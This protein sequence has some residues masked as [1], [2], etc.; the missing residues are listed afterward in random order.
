MNAIPRIFCV[1]LRE[2]PKRREEAIKYFQQ[3]GLQ[4]EMFDGIHGESFGLKTTIPNY[5]IVPGREYF[6]PQ[7][8]VGC[9][10]SHLM[11]WNVLIN[12]PDDEF[13]VV[14]DDI[15]LCDDFFEKFTKFKLELP[16][17]WQMAYIG[18]LPPGNKGGEDIVHVSENVVIPHPVCTHAYLV[19]KSALKILIETNQLAWSPL[20][21]QI[22]QRSLPKIK[23]YAS[24]IPLITQRSVF[25][26]KDEVW[27]SLCYDWDLNPEWIN[28][29]KNGNFRLGNGWHP[30][31]KNDEGYMIWTDGR[32]EFIFDDKWSKMKIDFI[33][34]GE[35]EK[36]LKVVCPSQADQIFEMPYGCQSITF[37]INGANSVVIV[38]DTFRPID[39]LK[40]SDCRRLGIRLLKGIMLTDM[41]GNEKFVSLYSMYGAKK[42]EEVRMVSGTGIIKLRYNHEDGKINL[43]GQF[44]YNHHRSGWEYV[45]GLLSEYH[46]EDATVFDT[47]LERSFSWE[48]QKTSQLRL[49]PYR[50]PWIGIFHN[51]PNI[52]SWFT[53]NGSPSTMLQSKEFKDSLPTCK[54]IYVLSKYH[55]DFLKCFIKSVPVEV[56]YHPTEIPEL[57]FSFDEFIK[58]NNKKLAN[59]GWWCRK[60]SSI[61]RLDVD[62]SVYQKICL[63]PDVVAGDPN[64][65]ERIMEVEKTLW[66]KELSED[67]KRSVVN[68]RHLSNGDYDELLSKNIVFMDLYDVSANNVIIEC[69][70]RGTPILINPLPAVKEYLGEEYPFYFTNL[71]EASTKLKNVGLIKTTHNYLVESGISEKITSAYFTKTIREGNIW[72]SLV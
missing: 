39:I 35:I 71:N 70:A 33:A 7:G 37:P 49:I 55:K 11:L 30:L 50:E 26:V 38:S 60:L 42:A 5:N 17:D 41:E 19:K 63:L 14:E 54:G 25:N 12:Q 59:I 27:Y 21:M 9:I 28:A 8:A 31:E 57:K 66:G 15:L 16:E 36:K 6:I 58:N 52:P 69:I 44:F 3:V 48:K 46:R 20:D 56:L 29:S 1:S 72:K 4:V 22:S 18:W 2:T 32:G 65:I 62:G 40:T 13:L 10:L 47:W 53:E 43:G 61:Y 68:I 45:L 51:P 67:M 34:E 24:K 64:I 23:Y